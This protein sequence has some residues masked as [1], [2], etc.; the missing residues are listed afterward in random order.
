MDILATFGLAQ[1]AYAVNTSTIITA[2]GTGFNEGADAGMEMVGN[3]INTPLIVFGLV[4]GIFLLM[5]FLRR[6]AR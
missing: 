3:N 2:V 1:P 4:I 6:G 5:K